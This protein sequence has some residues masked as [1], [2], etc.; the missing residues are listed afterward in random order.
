MAVSV[1]VRSVSVFRSV[2]VSVYVI[3]PVCLCRF[4]LFWSWSVILICIVCGIVD[5]TDCIPVFV[6]CSYIKLKVTSV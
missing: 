4:P 3:R 2:S 1:S 5:C 6:C